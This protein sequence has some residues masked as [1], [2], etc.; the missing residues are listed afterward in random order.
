MTIGELLQRS[1]IEH[2]LTQREIASMLGVSPQY[3]SDI[4]NNRK[5]VGDA[6]RLLTWAGLLDITNEDLILCG[7]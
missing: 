4:E 6:V 1:R 2:G 3:V 5:N 7:G